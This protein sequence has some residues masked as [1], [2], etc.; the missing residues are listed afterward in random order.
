[1]ELEGERVGAVRQWGSAAQKQHLAQAAGAR[2]GGD[3]SDFGEPS[4]PLG[5]GRRHAAAQHT[6]RV[7]LQAEGLLDPGAEGVGCEGGP[8]A[9]RWERRCQGLPQC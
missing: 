8:I 2:L 1:M 4:R 9:N 3:A 7:L 6:G 5:Q